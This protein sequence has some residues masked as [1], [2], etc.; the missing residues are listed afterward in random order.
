MLPAKLKD[1]YMMTDTKNIR[2]LRQW[3]CW[4]SETREGKPTKI[5]YS[6]HTSV[7]ASSTDPE[8]WGSYEEAVAACKKHGYG[9]IGFV[10]T[11]EDE[12][13]GVDLDGCL[14]PQTGEIEI[15]AQE[16]IDELNS[17]TEISPSGTGVHVLIRGTLPPGRNRKGRF[18]AYDRGRYFTVTGRHLTGTPLSIEFRQEQLERV[19]GRVF[20]SWAAESE[21]GHSANGSA[22]MPNGLVDDELVRKALSAS[23]GE[24]FARLWSGV[25]VGYGSHSEADLALC[26]MLAFWTGGDPDNVDEMFRRS[27]LY[28]SKWDERHYSDGKTYGQATIE[29][30]LES[31]T[32]FYPAADDIEW[33]DPVPLPDGLPPVA[34]L[35]PAMIPEP[36]RGW[37]VDVSERMQIPPDFAGAGAVVV[38]GSLIG[39]K[40]GVHPKRQDDWLV[41]PNLWGAVVGR[42]SLMK[43]PALAEVMK[44]LARLVAEAYEEHQ[45]AKLVYET[46]VLVADATKAALKDELK[47]AAREA[48]S[49]GNR[50]KLEEIARRGQDAE[51]P[52]EPVLRR[53]KTEDATV[54]KIS[55]ILLENPRGILV[56][57]DELS[58]WLRNLDKQ[59][60][61]GDRS[62]YLEAWNGTG[63]F[64]VDRIGRGSLHVPALC[65]SILGGIQPGPL[66]TYVYQATSG[67]KGDDGL[68]QRFQLLVWPDPPTS[69]RN[70]DRW[71]DTEAK[72]RA[73]QVFRRLDALNPEDF[74]VGGED[75]ESIPAVRFTDEAQEVFDRWR[76]ELEVKLRTG[77]LPS[78]LES[79]LAKYRSLMPS[80]AL[81]FQLIEYV[82]GTGEG[83]AVGLRSALQAAAWCEYLETH[84]TRLYSSAENPAVEGARALLDHIR[85][86]DVSDGDSTR[87]IYRRHWAKLSTPEEVNSACAVLE[88]FGW[89]RIE[90]V[91]TG[92]RSATRL[93]LHPLLSEQA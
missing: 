8:T 67:E 37:I 16:I 72:N 18:E 61:E 47:K 10:F 27:G 82:D 85:K 17:Y 59:G 57:R 26:R 58:G 93:R 31:A 53:Y 51:V 83:G 74:G 86:G 25:T 91:K 30:A 28:R 39:R 78:A 63:S 15:W 73:Y 6:P 64:N 11:A 89:L 5:P 75:E 87:S 68:L 3:L 36:L 70:V 40:V 43:S 23:N 69:W 32:E 92:G 34:C 88:E 62:F 21:N 50:S 90:A 1:A 54:E 14:D 81:V 76:D 20:G 42:P 7:R 29:K 52:E 49:S 46:D 22:P 38:A 44:P 60:R 66:S 33:E 77:E 80:L 56:H 79:H 65:L 24:R 71:P 84:A 55:E 45:E 48:A 9:G 19:V 13:C 12:L 41:V 4:H 35:D 2:D